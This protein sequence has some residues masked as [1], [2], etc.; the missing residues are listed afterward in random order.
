MAAQ[1]IANPEEL[2]RFAHELKRF[3]AQLGESMARLNGQFVRLGDTWR[4]Q[5]HQKFAQ[6]FEQTVRVLHHFTRTADQHIP[7]L[8]RKAQRLRDFLNQR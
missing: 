2:E 3:N 7:F 5:E 8:L 6:E 1:V 4:D